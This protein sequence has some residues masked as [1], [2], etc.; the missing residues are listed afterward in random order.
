MVN[1]AIFSNAKNHKKSFD[2]GIKE[3]TDYINSLSEKYTVKNTGRGR[4]AEAPV[5][6]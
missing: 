6:I 3:A 5:K 2:H 1:F 4:P